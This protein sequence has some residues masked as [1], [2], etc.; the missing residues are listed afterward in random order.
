MEGV[1][2]DAREWQEV[3]RG[4]RD[5]RIYGGGREGEEEVGWLV[6]GNSGVLRQVRRE[7]RRKVRFRGQVVGVVVP[8]DKEG[9]RR[10]SSGQKGQ[11][12]EGS[13]PDKLPPLLGFEI[14]EGLGHGRAI[15]ALLKFAFTCRRLPTL[16]HTICNCF[17]AS[18]TS[19]ET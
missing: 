14:V 12:N 16:E 10:R 6:I 18:Q 4:G 1:G 7:D 2:M 15:K 3:E 17:H 13:E 9:W 11:Q 19:Q 8:K 5:G